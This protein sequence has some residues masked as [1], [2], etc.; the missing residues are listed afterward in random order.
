MVMMFHHEYQMGFTNLQLKAIHKQQINTIRFGNLGKTFTIIGRIKNLPF[1]TKYI[2][3]HSTL[4][5]QGIK[6]NKARNLCIYDESYS[7]R[8]V[9]WLNGDVQVQVL[10]NGNL[11]KSTTRG[12]CQ[13]PNK[14][15]GSKGY[16]LE[17]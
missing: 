17:V 12:G 11:C 9:I 1:M 14:S 6:S 3:F 13:V 5:F 2:F 7:C 4:I 10:E 16:V 15:G 8:Y